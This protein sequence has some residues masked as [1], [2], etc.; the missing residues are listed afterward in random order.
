MHR[1]LIRALR[2]Q[3]YNAS[4]I[5]SVVFRP[6]DALSA[7]SC[8]AVDI[9]FTLMFLTNRSTS[10]SQSQR[11]HSRRT[12]HRS[13]HTRDDGYDALL[14]RENSQRRNLN[15]IHRRLVPIYSWNS[16][17]NSSSVI[18]G[19]SRNTGEVKLTSFSCVWY[20]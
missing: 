9:E 20:L 10:S 12:A 1:C 4:C 14:S 8:R 18:G 6:R 11:T 19:T 17:A 16:L 5:V 2:C 13:Q 7:C 15:A 3:N